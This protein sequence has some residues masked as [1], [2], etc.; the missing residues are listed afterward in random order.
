MKK[1]ASICAIAM[2]LITST[3]Q[4]DELES[5]LLFGDSYFDTGAGNA[6]AESL[7]LL[8]PNPTPPYFDNR[9]SN[10]PIWIDFTSRQLHVPFVDY[11]V[12]G[13][14]T[15][16]Q[17][18]SEPQLGGI[19]T[20]ILRYISNQ[21]PIDSETIV[22]LD[23]GGNDYLALLD[24]P[25][26]LNPAGVANVTETA[27]TNQAV[28]LLT[29]EAIGAKRTIIWNLG[30]LGMLPLFTDPALGLTA[31]APLFTAASEAYNANLITTVKAI[32]DSNLG[33]G[34]VYIFDAKG[35]FDGIAA[36]LREA[37]FNLTEHTITTL[38]N[39]T[40]IITGPQPDQT[41]FYDQVHPTSLVWRMFAN[42]ITAFTN[43]IADG[44]RFIAAEQD[45]A[46]ETTRAFREAINNHFRT[47]HFQ[48]YLQCRDWCNCSEFERYQ[49]YLD[50]LAKWGSTNTREGTLGYHYDTQ[51]ALFGI[52]Y[53][54]SNNWTFGANFTA[55]RNY[56]RLKGNHRHAGHIH[57]NDYA[58]AIYAEY[59]NCDF[60]VDTFFA[61]HIYDF[62]RIRRKIP[63]IDVSTKGRTYGNGPEF[64]IQAGYVIPYMCST[65]IPII[66]LD[67]EYIH[68]D[69]YKEKHGIGILDYNLRV[70][71]NHN[72]SLVGKFGAQ[73]FLNPLDCGLVAFG[74]LFWEQEF[75]RHRKGIRTH[76][77]H[78]I[79]DG[80]TIRNRNSSLDRSLLTYSLGLQSQI[81]SQISAN[82]SYQGQTTFRRYN[83]AIKGEVAST[84]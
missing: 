15:G 28:N 37:G 7:G 80:S 48:R 46:F 61:W 34:Q 55:Q 63:G 53:F 62:R 33:S 3:S 30:D 21:P 6:I 81:T 4:A 83:N 9:H 17:N 26:M 52:D 5:L 71:Q 13:A 75:L 20:Q 58:P 44:P 68:I 29:L 36:R 67:Y 23:G 82:I 79:N 22:I 10:G 41:A 77:I 59:S 64:D 1:W 2:S 78:G 73:F 72:D 45:L 11:G 14:Q 42:E 18:T 60:F 69:R 31:L 40:F 35:V 39:G 54:W 47:L 12:A 49:V 65:L 57:L 84:F 50:G 43:T 25:S 56:A 24:D 51:L 16:D 66:G 38:P 8:L 27:L 70:R 76:F 74:E 32:N 19:H